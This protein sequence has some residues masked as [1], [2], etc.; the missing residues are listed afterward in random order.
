MYYSEIVDY[1]NSFF[2][3]TGSIVALIFVLLVV[4]TYNER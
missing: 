1:I 2:I 3:I 4:F